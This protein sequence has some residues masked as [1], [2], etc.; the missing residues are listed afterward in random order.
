MIN[1]KPEEIKIE[2]TPQCNLSCKFCFN[3]NTY[4]ISGKRQTQQ[5]T[6]N[7]WIK[8]IDKIVEAGIPTI[9]FTG[10]EPLVR[11]DI[12]DLF[13][14]A[15]LKGLYV[16]LNTNGILINKNNVNILERCVDEVLIPLHTSNA[17][18]EKILTGRSSFKK[19][20]EA[21]KLLSK[22]KIKLRIDTC[23][24]KNTIKNLEK[25]HEFIKTFNLDWF[26]ERPIPN[27]DFMYPINNSDVKLL[28]E[29]IIKINKKYDKNYYISGL[30][31]CSYDPEKT[32]LISIGGQYCGPFSILVIDPNGMVKPCYSIN[33]NLG[34]IFSSDIFELW[35]H[36]FCKKLRSFNHDFFPQTCVEC[37]YL[38][39]CMGGC[40]FSAKLVNGSYAS[41][42]PLANPEKYIL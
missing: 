15:K 39:N 16:K 22:S 7:E 28:V 23:P 26:L 17:K 3:K 19:K 8:A 21:I 6:T 32:K 18:S 25:I 42:D 5:L 34:N 12:F 29:K 37:D 10:G 31:L 27:K 2:V 11:K 13:L 20:L 41:M 40:R 38:K 4:L 35:N 30:P 24:T 36:E 14:Y 33:E 1:T 9:R